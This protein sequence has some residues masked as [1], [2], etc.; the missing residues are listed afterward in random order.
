MKTREVVII[1]TDSSVYTIRINEEQLEGILHNVSEGIGTICVDSSYSTELIHLAA[2][3]VKK[4][5]IKKPQEG[6]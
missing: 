6:N 1:M 5:K 2:R 4:L 3:H